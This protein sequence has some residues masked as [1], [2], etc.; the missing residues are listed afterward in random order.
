MNK[1][2]YSNVKCAEWWI[3]AKMCRS[4]IV[5]LVD[6]KREV[7]DLRSCGIHPNLTHSYVPSTRL[8]VSLTPSAWQW[9]QASSACAKMTSSIKPEVHNASL[10]RNSRI[11]PRPQVTYT[12]K[13]DEDR[14][15][16]SQDMVANT[17]QHNQWRSNYIA[18]STRWENTLN[19]IQHYSD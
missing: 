5:L 18:A 19:R 7:S 8:R 11:E 4:S 14:T 6:L 13:F 17:I 2:K 15:C 16:I 1:E 3:A 12:K 9:R 10:C